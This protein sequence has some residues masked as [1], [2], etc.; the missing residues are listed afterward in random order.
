MPMPP[1][2]RFCLS[3]SALLARCFSSFHG[4]PACPASQ[5]RN[6]PGRRLALGRRRAAGAASLGHSRPSGRRRGH[7]GR[8]TTGPRRTARCS[9]GKDMPT[10]RAPTRSVSTGRPPSPCLTI[11]ARSMGR[12]AAR[13]R[14][15]PP[16]TP[17]PPPSSSPTPVPRTVQSSLQTPGA[18]PPAPR[19]RASANVHLYRPVSEGA[20]TSYAAGTLFT[21]QTLA[22]SAK[23]AVTRFMDLVGANNSTQV[24]WSDRPL[25]GAWNQ[26]FM[27]YEYVVAYG[28]ATSTD[29]YV[30]VPLEA[31]PAY[32]TNLGQPDPLRLGRGEPLH[33]GAKQPRLPRRST[34]GC[35]S[36]WNTATR[37]GTSASNK[38]VKTATS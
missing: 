27:A 19:T 37:S 2:L 36:T 13:A 3:L 30:N 31:T 16:P 38:P 5:R 26:A 7:R 6:Q 1:N 33:L 34:P 11:M 15:T 24:N 25:P 29:I 8:Q 28:N 18:P 32:F 9:S 21:N 17:R 10:M 14:T 35:M 22:M 20:S 12:L 4:P 23:F